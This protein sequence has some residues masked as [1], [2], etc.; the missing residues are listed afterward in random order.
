MS[1][2]VA[3]IEYRVRR[4][5]NGFLR[6]LA[7]AFGGFSDY[8]AGDYLQASTPPYL[9]GEGS[10]ADSDNPPSPAGERP[11][12]HDNYLRAAQLHRRV[13][14]GP[15]VSMHC[16]D[17]GSPLAGEHFSTCPAGVTQPQDDPPAGLSWVD[18][19]APAICD[20]LATHLAS[21]LDSDHV[22]RIKG[23]VWCY[24]GPGQPGEW[25]TDWQDWREHVAPLI[26]ER[27][28]TAGAQRKPHGPYEHPRA[29]ETGHDMGVSA[30]SEFF[31]QYR[32]PQK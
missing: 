22:N 1:N 18:W 13:M 20:V 16:D 21:Q 3:H 6:G 29:W 24:H 23:E 27:L 19:A 10:P 28:E 11:S 31:P 17:C 12:D 30:A 8:E 32:K 7:E 4:F 9:A 14:V 2:P 26:A 25:F 15:A 5:A